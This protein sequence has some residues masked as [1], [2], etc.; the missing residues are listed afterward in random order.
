MC[1]VQHLIEDSLS[2]LIRSEN[3]KVSAELLE[4]KNNDVIVDHVVLVTD[5]INT[6]T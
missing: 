5:E 2:F 3:L 4:G 6:Y 1:D